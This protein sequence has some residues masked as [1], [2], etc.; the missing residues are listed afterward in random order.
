MSLEAPH[1]RH[2]KL[3]QMKVD[4]GREVKCYVGRWGKVSVHT[5]SNLFVKI[6]TE[7]IGRCTGDDS[8]FAA[9]CKDVSLDRR[10]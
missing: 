9:P 1:G 6:L 4:G 2:M 10:K 3:G 7:E 8:C 5:S